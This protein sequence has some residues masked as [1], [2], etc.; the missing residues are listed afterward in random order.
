M[1]RGINVSGQK[2]IKMDAL[3]QLYEK[4]GFFNV[5]SYLQSG[6][7]IFTADETAESELAHKIS[8][9]VKNTFGF[10]VPVIVLSIEALSTIIKQ[11]PLLFHANI[12]PSFLHVTFLASEPDH[13]AVDVNTIIAKKQGGEEV[14]FAN[15]VIYLYCPN[16]YGKTKL[17][18]NL[19]ESRLG[20]GATTRN[21]KTTN[22]LVKMAESTVV[23][24]F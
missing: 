2:L 19:L 23:T 18:N 13:D 24:N 1:L 15:S 9:D 4:L 6:N 10:D 20:V 22:E 5:K 8:E 17:T 7:V 14:T 3:R 11:N 12:D 16:G 21:W